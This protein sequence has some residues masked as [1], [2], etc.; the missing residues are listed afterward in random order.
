MEKKQKSPVAGPS[1]QAGES[2]LRRIPRHCPDGGKGSWGHRKGLGKREGPQEGSFVEYV[3]ST[4]RT[5]EPPGART[6]AENEMVVPS[7][8]LGIACWFRGIPTAWTLPG[9]VGNDDVDDGPSLVGAAGNSAPTAHADGSYGSCAAPRSVREGR[10]ER[11]TRE[12]LLF[13]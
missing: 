11:R 12:L 8:V 2:H 7:L 10:G 4:C 1:G 13:N 5:A 6:A 3:Q 9:A